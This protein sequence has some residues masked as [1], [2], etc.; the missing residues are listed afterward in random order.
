MNI[1]TMLQK[2]LLSNEGV[3]KK[4]RFKAAERP[5]S[6]EKYLDC[7]K[8]VV[9]LRGIKNHS[10]YFALQIPQNNSDSDKLCFYYAKLNSW[11]PAIL[12]C[13]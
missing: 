1:K 5:F 13:L 9:E 6:Y 10:N 12:K 4:W 2:C 3:E 8:L 7:K 11:A